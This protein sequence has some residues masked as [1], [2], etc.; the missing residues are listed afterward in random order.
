[1]NLY[2]DEHYELSSTII[3][4]CE[5]GILAFCG[6]G[7]MLYGMQIDEFKKSFNGDSSIVFIKDL[8]RS[9]WNNGCI[10]S[11]IAKAV[12]HL[13]ENGTKR[14]YAIGNS[15]GASGALLAS[16]LREDITRVYAFVPQAD[17]YLDPRW[18]EYTDTILNIKWHNFANL[19]FNSDVH[20]FMGTQGPD[21]MQ[22]ELFE[23][24]GHELR[25]VEGANH[26]AAQLLKE[27]QEYTSIINDFLR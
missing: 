24:A 6:V 1:M 17:P 4:G 8:H 14:V 27:R 22:S 19:D 7:N 9:W 12:N 20:I 18:N 25:I 2:V 26:N 16:H 23:K 10:Q 21:L 15:M 5:T 3:T 13:K 11:L